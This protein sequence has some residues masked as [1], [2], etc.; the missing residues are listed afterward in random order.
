MFIGDGAAPRMISTDGKVTTLAGVGG[1]GNVDGFGTIA[2]FGRL[3]HLWLTP[4]GQLYM[5]DWTNGN[6]R[7]LDTTG[8]KISIFSSN[9]QVLYVWIGFCSNGRY[10]SVY[11]TTNCITSPAGYYK[12]RASFSD[13]YYICSPGTYAIAGST[14]CSSCPTSSSYGVTFCLFPTSQPTGQPSRNPTRQ[15]TSSPSQQPTC[16]PS[17]QPSSRPTAQPS[18][19]PTL[20]CKPG[21]TYSFSSGKCVVVPAGKYASSA[22]ASNCSLSLYPGAAVC[23]STQGK[24]SLKF[25]LV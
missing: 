13:E 5:P 18:S 16:Q 6:V 24:P 9:I 4:T 7:L 23:Q 17:R 8:V 21:S 20:S 3:V 2:R 22:T 1:G 11:G 14:V 19:H 12:P 10:A 15:P 25:V